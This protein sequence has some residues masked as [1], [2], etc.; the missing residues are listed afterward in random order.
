MHQHQPSSISRREAIRRATV[1]AGGVA[2]VGSGALVACTS[3][4]REPARGDTARASALDADD[5]ALA[6][7]VADTILPDTAASPGARAAGAGAAMNLLLTDCYDD[8]AQQRVRDGLAELRSRCRTQCGAGFAS[9]A[10]PERERILREFD[11]RAKAEAKSEAKPAGGKHWFDLV[12]ELSTRAYFSSE[13][14]T[15][16]AL[17]WM[18][19]PGR[20]EGCVPLQPGQRAWA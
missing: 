5:R 16:K 13:V 19:V 3:E 9:L 10:Q 11:A 6:E 7:A 18:L 17:R 12:H 8:E 20:W 4:K 15:T 2:L 14:G 1:I